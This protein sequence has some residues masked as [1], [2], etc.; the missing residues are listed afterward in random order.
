MNRPKISDIL[1]FS[2]Q[3]I[4]EEIS[5][6]EIAIFNLRFKKATKQTFKS[7]ELKFKKKKLAQLKTLLTIK[8]KEGQKKEKN[9]LNKL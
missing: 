9:K 7:H 4:I 1:F 5:N 8:V 6:T 3:Q 2:N